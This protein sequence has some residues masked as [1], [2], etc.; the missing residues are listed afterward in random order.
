MS[1]VQTIIQTELAEG[2]VTVL[3]P[4]VQ[5]ASAP[6]TI[7]SAGPRVM[8]VFNVA[9]SNTIGRSYRFYITGLIVAANLVQA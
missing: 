3:P 9:P 5:N 6:P 7:P 2:P 4:L 1:A 8:R